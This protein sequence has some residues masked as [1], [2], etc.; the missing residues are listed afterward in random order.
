MKASTYH[1]N[2]V[3]G[4]FL[5]GGLLLGAA[6]SCGQESEGDTFTG[7]RMVSAVITARQGDDS[8]TRTEL[9]GNT[10]T[11]VLWSP[12]DAISV[13][14]AGETT[15]FETGI[16]SASATAAF[17]GSVALDLAREGIDDD[18]WGL[19]PYDAHARYSDGVVTT[20]LP[21]IQTGKANSFSQNLM[22][23]L[24]RASNPL[25]AGAAT[26][27]GG[28]Q[29]NMDFYHICSG[30]RF[31]VAEE[32]IYSVTVTARG[33]EALAGTFRV[34]LNASGKPEVLGV[35][36]ASPSVTLTAPQGGFV[37]GTWYY[38]VTL[39]GSL[40]EGVDFAVDAEDGEGTVKIHTPFQLARK[41][42]LSHASLDENLI[43]TPTGDDPAHEVEIATPDTWVAVDELG[44]S[45]PDY[46]DVGERKENKH[47]VLFYWTWH[48]ENQ[49]NYANIFN[50]S[51]V[52]RSWPG[53]FDNSA[54]WSGNGG[55][56][57]IDWGY[58]YNQICFWGKP[59]FG[60]YRTT[61]GWVL[62]KHAEMLADAGVDAVMFDCTN[63][64]LL[65][66]PAVDA[67]L[68]TWM[69]A[70]ADGVK[71]PQVG[72]ILNLIADSNAAWS[73]RRIYKKYY[74]NSA[75]ADMWFKVDGKPLVMAFPQS[76]NTSTVGPDSDNDTAYD[77]AIRQ[78]FTFRPG[79]GD[80]VDGDIY[81]N[82]WGWMQTAPHMNTFS[83][84]EQI[85]V[86]V[87]QNASDASGGHCFAFNSPD[88]YG[89]SYT[90]QYK[91]TRTNSTSYR[92]GYNFQEQ[93]D[94]ALA[95]GT[96]YVFVTGWNEWIAA[97]QYQWP[98]PEHNYQHA[99][100]YN[101][102]YGPPSFADQYDW[103][104]SRDSEPTLEWGDH[105]DNYYNQLAQNI[106]RY[107]GVSKYPWV[108]RAV[109][110][111]IDGDFTEWENVSPDFRHY[112]GNTMH[113]Y[114]YGHTNGT[115]SNG[116]LIYSNNTGRNDI[117]DAKVTRDG[118]YLYFY[119][120][121]AANLT[122]YTDSKW[123]RLLINIDY[124]WTT[125]W[126]GYD[127]CLN[128]QTPNSATEGIVSRCSGTTWNWTNAGTFDYRVVGN[129]MELRV[130][131][132]VLGVSG[133]RLNFA[134]KWADNNLIEWENGHGTRI[135]N[136]YV[137]GD[138]APGGR[139]NFHY[140]ER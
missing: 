91:N 57:P 101:G 113:R 121:T 16:Q 93:W 18:I 25:T 50:V 47:V 6:V 3:F 36:D 131:R 65:W 122:A 75:Y 112:P 72:F 80:Y 60:Y 95:A 110:V 124:D 137:D 127:Y 128:L 13:F 140:K 15:R 46:N 89:R 130:A 78:F 114:H 104:H 33:G 68:S 97:M 115:G 31:K 134:F 90:Y 35:D 73:L 79:Q 56:H 12:G 77:A 38:I 119:V 120:E 64:H 138:S 37:P 2:P 17:T 48:C 53:H 44:R 39:P 49:V 51:E 109:T 133:S 108:S 58:G 126:K 43:L 118:E 85:T 24:G 1:I 125:G 41:E 55:N 83:G 92:Y 105:G 61:D 76:L 21:T 23:M 100:T 66:E 98:A 19:Y 30:I 74:R 96:P 81:G 82:Q 29:V 14:S 5:A 67:L 84:G 11:T 71:V 87:S 40:S 42:F 135:L 59:L 117:V 27:S 94:Y 20:T 26:P 103:E 10:L 106:R 22:L 123:M 28:C 52:Q 7:L 129:K 116:Y 102:V 54:L 139:F 111:P 70:K 63:G 132:S 9:S 69:Q 136:L 107:K 88:T 86:S 99:P 4:A 34:G 45:M 8:G 32:G 62:R